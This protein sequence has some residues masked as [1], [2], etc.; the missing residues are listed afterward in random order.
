MILIF[1]YLHFWLHL[2]WQK[3]DS[4]L[5]NIFD[6]HKEMLEIILNYMDYIR[7]TKNGKGSEDVVLMG[8]LEALI[9]ENSDE[10]VISV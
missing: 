3:G 6:N 1:T 8:T 9:P 10:M 5:V 7:T 4:R 2:V